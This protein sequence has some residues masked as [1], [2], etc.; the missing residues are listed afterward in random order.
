MYVQ[1]SDVLLFVL[2]LLH[3]GS[4]SRGKFDKRTL[5][6]RCERE[7]RV[8]GRVSVSVCP[9]ISV[10]YFVRP[11]HQ[12]LTRHGVT[13]SPMTMICFSP[14]D[15]STKVVWRLRNQSSSQQ[16]W[17]F[18][19]RPRSNR[20]YFRTESGNTRDT[21]T[22]SKTQ[23][24][25]IPNALNCVHFVNLTTDRVSFISSIRLITVK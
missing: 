14:F 15:S 20:D 3:W 4:P 21:G 10:W 22:S 16:T 9:E 13:W 1:H 7:H 25:N 17:S 12:V 5:R 2:S 19:V 8:T 23:V 11:L 18:V 6:V 24:N